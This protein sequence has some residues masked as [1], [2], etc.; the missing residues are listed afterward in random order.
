MSSEVRFYHL[1]L[2]SEEQVLPML[3]SKALERGHKIVVKFADEGAMSRMDEYLWT[4][5]AG[6]FLP[7]GSAKSGRAQ[8]Q[9]IWLTVE[10]ENPNEADVL[11]LCGGALSPAYGGYSLCC[12]M[13]NG[14]DPEALN[15]ARG[16]WKQYKDAGVEVTYWQQDER[17]GWAKK[18]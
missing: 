15:A 17:G 13:L 7:H 14:H 5:N 4:Y 16:R 6:S 2:Q 9:P 1:E 12:E 11:I 8:A 10:D 18:A 3:L